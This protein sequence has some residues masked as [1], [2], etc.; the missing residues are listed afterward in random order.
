MSSLDCD[1]PVAELRKA[2]ITQGAVPPE[3]T[4]VGQGLYDALL[5][6]SERS[7]TENGSSTRSPLQLDFLCWLP[8][9]QAVALAAS[10]EVTSGARVNS[11]F[12]IISN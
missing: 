1:N 10:L 12:F 11:P 3:L 7:A 5:L 8:P 6:A 4:Q 2:R 9:A